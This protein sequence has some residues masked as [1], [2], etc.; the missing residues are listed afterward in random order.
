MP[1]A[2]TGDITMSLDGYSNPSGNYTFIG[3]ENTS[4][5]MDDVPPDGYTSEYLE[6]SFF[7]YYFYS[8]VTGQVTGFHET[9]NDSLDYAARMAFGRESSGKVYTFGSSIL[10]VGQWKNDREDYW[11]YCRLRVLGNG[12]MILPY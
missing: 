3:W 2:W 11:F 4:P 6:Y 7:I 10:N 5:F 9:I 8:Y 12:D 1:Y